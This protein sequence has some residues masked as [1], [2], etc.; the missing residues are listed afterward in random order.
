MDKH[1]NKTLWFFMLLILPVALYAQKDVT[2]FLGIPVDGSKSEMIQKLKSKGYTISPYIN[3]VLVGEFNGTDVNIHIATNNN[4]VC[5]IMVAD[6]NTIGETDIRIRFNKLI[7]QFQ[8]NKKYIPLPESTISQ[9]NIP[10][11]ENISYEL[12]IK[13]KR[14][15]ALFYQKTAVYDSLEIEMGNLLKKENPNDA[16][17]ERLS[18][19]KAKMLDEIN[20]NKVVWFMIS[21]HDGKYFISMFY[22]NEYNR[23]NGE[24]L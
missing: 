21:E 14:Y 10:E 7:Q 3:D 5:R 24:D 18:V 11:D 12:L 20:F 17:K 9:Y 23:A 19:V 22:D 13:N 6:A 8:N 1:F 4:K 2:Q 15:E 16:E